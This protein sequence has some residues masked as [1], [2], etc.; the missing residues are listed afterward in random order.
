MRAAMK[1]R[2]VFVESSPRQFIEDLFSC[3]TKSTV[4]C[5]RLDFEKTA[6]SRFSWRSERSTLVRMSGKPTRCCLRMPIPECRVWRS[7]TPKYP[8]DS[9]G[10]PAVGMTA[11]SVA[12]TSVADSCQFICNRRQRCANG[13]ARP[14]ADGRPD[15]LA[16]TGIRVKQSLDTVT[17]GEVIGHSGARDCGIGS[18]YFRTVTSSNTAIAIKN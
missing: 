5:E 3:A 10:E 4:V 2:S 9:E 1:C 14:V 17:R 11:S 15:R 16:K 18:I 12:R 13:S 6:E 7:R 8:A